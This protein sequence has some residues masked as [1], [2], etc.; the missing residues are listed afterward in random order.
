M[1]GITHMIAVSGSNVALVIAFSNILVIKLFGKKYSNYI[2]ILFIIFFVFISGATPSVVRAGIMAILNLIANILYKRSNG[3]IN[4]I[5]SAFF[6]LVYNPLSIVNIGFLL[7]FAGTLGIL[8]FSKE[9]KNLISKYIK[10]NFITEIISLN[11]SAQILIFPITLYFFNTF[12]IVGIIANL[13]IVP[14]TSILTFLGIILLL[15]S[16]ISLNIASIISV[17]I[18]PLI[19]YIL[20]MSKIFAGFDFLN[21]IVPTPKIWMILFFYVLLYFKYDY[22][23]RLKENYLLKIN[24][25]KNNIMKDNSK[26]L[27]YIVSSILLSTSIIIKVIPKNYIEFTAIDVGQGDSFLFVTNEG[28]KVLIDGGGSEMNEYDV[29][30]NILMP[31]LLDRGF[32]KIDYVFLSHAHADHIDG[33]YTVLENFKVKTIFIGPQLENDVMIKKLKQMALGKNIR[34]LELHE[35]QVINIDEMKIEILFPNKD[36]KESN[37]NNLSLIMK[38][39]CY[40]NNILFTGDAE[41]KVELELL[42]KYNFKVL[43]VDILKVGHHGAKTSSSDEFIQVVSPKISIISVAKENTY[44]HPNK[45]IVERLKKYGQVLQ[46]SELGEINFKIYNNGK[47]FQNTI[48]K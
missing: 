47:I 20:I 30:K 36:Y 11:F 5:S 24:N 10:A 2:S 9:I 34:I 23:L 41:E 3:V 14:I 37:V 40:G 19:N 33:I 25:M 32:C 16:L 18:N 38:V 17:I 21:L 43:D 7:S 45:E 26:K 35:G 27:V 12:S 1:A 48:Y 4:T 29:G 28:K 6:I 13:F 31:Y 8:T 15:V 44:G 22:Y 42:K 39:N 46:T